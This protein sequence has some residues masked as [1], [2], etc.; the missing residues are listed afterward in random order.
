M[1]PHDVEDENDDDDGDDDKESHLLQPQQLQCTLRC[2]RTLERF[3]HR[4]EAVAAAEEEEV[5]RFTRSVA[6]R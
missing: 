4:K 2:N 1:L 5:A 3:S 6:S